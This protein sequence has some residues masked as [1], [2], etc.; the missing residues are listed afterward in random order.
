MQSSIEFREISIGKLSKYGTLVLEKRIDAPHLLSYLP[1]RDAQ[2]TQNMQAA[3]FKA[4]FVYFEFK[5][6]LVC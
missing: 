3:I 2:Q 4:F 6:T 1:Y 5:N